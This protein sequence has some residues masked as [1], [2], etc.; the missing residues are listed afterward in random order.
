M[1]KPSVTEAA[2][3]STSSLKIFRLY[4]VVVT[5][6]RK[7]AAVEAIPAIS[8]TV[9]RSGYIAMGTGLSTGA[10]VS[11]LTADWA[12]KTNCE[13]VYNDQRVQAADHFNRL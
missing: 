11:I 3:P 2:P 12:Y 5:W 6:Y 8:R 13:A 10:P 1:P 9:A 4:R 7:K